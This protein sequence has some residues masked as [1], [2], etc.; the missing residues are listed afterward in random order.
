MKLDC[1]LVE[2]RSGFISFKVDDCLLVD[3]M[4]RFGCLHVENFM[5]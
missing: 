3:V 5:D 2:Q 4:N 1:W